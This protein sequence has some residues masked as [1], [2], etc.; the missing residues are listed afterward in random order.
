MTDD[1]LNS[2]SEFTQLSPYLSKSN[3]KQM[4]NVDREYQ[5]KQKLYDIKHTINFFKFIFRHT[6]DSINDFRKI[7]FNLFVITISHLHVVFFFERCIS[8][9]S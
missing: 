8:F 3:T 9:G 4:R 2:K 1:R 5:H 7:L 6:S